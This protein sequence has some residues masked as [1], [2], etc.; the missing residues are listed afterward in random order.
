MRKDPDSVPSLWE[1]VAH[2]LQEMYTEAVGWTGEKARIGVKRMD[3]LNLQRQIRRLMAELGGRVYDL[4]RRGASVVEDAAVQRLI[5][6]IRRLE[7][8]LGSRE[9]EI[10]AL[11][12]RRSSGGDERDASGKVTDE[13]R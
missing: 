3:I 2:N 10:D 8:E 12:G 13:E 4:S 1:K 11:K 5:E 6:E 7:R 9:E